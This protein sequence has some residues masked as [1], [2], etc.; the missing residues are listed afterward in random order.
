M[1]RIASLM[2]PYMR[3]ECF[4]LDHPEINLT[5]ERIRRQRCDPTCHEEVSRPS[6]YRDVPRLVHQR[7]GPREVYG[8]PVARGVEHEREPEPRSEHVF[9]VVQVK[10]LGPAHGARVKIVV[11]SDGVVENDHVSE[12]ILASE[13]RRVAPRGGPH[14]GRSGVL[15]IM[16]VVDNVVEVESHVPA[17]LAD[18][19]PGPGP[20][21]R[22]VYYNCT[23]DKS[24]LIYPHHDHAPSNSSNDESVTFGTAQVNS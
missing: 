21:I 8:A 12:M 11:E 7:V 18:S 15:G 16:A 10:P 9:L 5:L 23:G 19:G 3:D 6:N 2:S 20:S 4:W 24:N 14:D 22:P 13:D 1:G 17:W